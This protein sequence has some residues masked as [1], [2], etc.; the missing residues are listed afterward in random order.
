MCSFQYM[1]NQVKALGLTHEFWAIVIL[2]LYLKV[3]ITC[4][5]KSVGFKA[6]C[7]EKLVNSVQKTSTVKLLIADGGGQYIIITLKEVVLDKV[8][9]RFSRARFPLDE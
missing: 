9:S 6:I 1:L 2:I 7:S 3:E 5:Q 8:T 4:Y